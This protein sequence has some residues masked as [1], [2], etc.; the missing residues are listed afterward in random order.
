MSLA[1]A[2]CQLSNGYHGGKVDSHLKSNKL[3][4]PQGVGS[5]TFSL[6]TYNVEVPTFSSKD[7]N[8]GFAGESQYVIYDNAC[9]IKGIYGTSADCDILSPLRRTSLRM[10]SLSRVNFLNQVARSL[11]SIM[12]MANSPRGTIIV[13][14]RRSWTAWQQAQGVSARFPLMEG[15]RSFNAKAW[16]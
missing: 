7:P 13:D 16:E 14:V 10:S 4:V 11:C 3:C 5:W 6:F 1:S 15:S 12:A 2:L 9:N 8:A